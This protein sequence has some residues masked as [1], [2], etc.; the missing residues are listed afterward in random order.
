MKS[1]SAPVGCSSAR[2]QSACTV[3]IPTSPAPRTSVVEPVADE[4]RVVGLDA[5][6]LERPLEDRRV[7]LP[8]AD[9]DEKT[10]VDAL[11]DPELLEH[12]AAASQAGLGRVRD[13]AELEP[14]PAQRLE[15]RVRRRAE[16]RRRPHAVVLG[17]EE[18]SSSSATLD[19][20][21]AEQRRSIA[22]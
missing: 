14:A 17:L 20:E 10:R 11:G 8:L 21:V 5:E 19:A 6:L 13:D 2:N 16:R 7:R 9:L 15:Q 1:G 12:R 22:G 18:P 4:H 3:I